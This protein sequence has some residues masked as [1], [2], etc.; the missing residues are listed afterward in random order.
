MTLPHPS[1]LAAVRSDRRKDW[2]NIIAAI[3]AAA[4]PVLAGKEV[5]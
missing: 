2:L 5:K 4:K 1:D 3:Q